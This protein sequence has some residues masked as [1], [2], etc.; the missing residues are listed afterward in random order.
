MSHLHQ[1][2]DQWDFPLKIIAYKN[3]KNAKVILQSKQTDSWYGTD[4]RRF[5]LLSFLLTLCDYKRHL[6]GIERMV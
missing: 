4:F 5:I 6:S 3:V 2:V 1:P